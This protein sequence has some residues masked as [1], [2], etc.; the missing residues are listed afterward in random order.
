[1]VKTTQNVQNATSAIT[2][3]YATGSSKLLSAKESLDRIQ[4]RQQDTEDRLK[5]G[6]TL[7]AEFEGEDLEKKLKEAG[8]IKTENKAQDILD[9]IKAKKNG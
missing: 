6:E 1:M 4:A 9:Q 3:N 5:A 2:E 8:I 7:K